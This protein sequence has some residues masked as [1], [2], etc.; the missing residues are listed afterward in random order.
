[1]PTVMHQSHPLFHVHDRHP[2]LHGLP[3]VL[4][5]LAFVLAFLFSVMPGV[6]GLLDPAASQEATP[7]LVP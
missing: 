2:L 1:M 7:G 4:L 5:C 6:V 3:V